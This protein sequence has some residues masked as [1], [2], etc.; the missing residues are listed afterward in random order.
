MDTGGALTRPCTDDGRRGIAL[1]LT[2]VLLLLVHLLALAMWARVRGAER[3]VAAERRRAL[4]VEALE[5]ALVLLESRVRKRL[6][7]PVPPV[8]G[9]LCAGPDGPGLK[10]ALDYP[11][12]PRAGIAPG[13]L[14]VRARVLPVGDARVWTV[15]RDPDD[16]RPRRERGGGSSWPLPTAATLV[17]PAPYE[18]NELTCFSRS[19]C[20]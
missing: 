18:P 11:L 6:V 17:V 16:G 15:D 14:A 3:R 8:P 13:T 2:L 10:V 4:R 19:S 5:Y 9:E 1:V 7:S 12:A 20:R